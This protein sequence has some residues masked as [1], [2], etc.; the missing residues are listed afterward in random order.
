MRGG[1]KYHFDVLIIGAGM[2]GA[3]VA[4]RLAPDARVAL[5]EMEDQPGYHTTGRSA[6]IFTE[7]YGPPV[8]RA[9]TSLSRDFLE[10]PP[11]GFAE[12]PL[13][14]PRGILTFAADSQ[15]P[16]LDQLFR[17]YGSVS[18]IRRVERAEIKTLV[19]LLRDDFAISGLLE[20]NARDIDVHALHQGF[21][22][23]I[24]KQGGAVLT[25]MEVKRID[26]AGS[27]WALHT[28][29]GVMSAPVIVNAAG[30]WADQIA[31]MAGAATVG[32]V[33]KRRTVVIVE[34]PAGVDATAWP[35]VGDVDD[36]FY[37]KPDSGRF[38]LSPADE[39]PSAPCDAQP[40]EL[41]VATCIERVE[42]AFDLKIRRIENSW[43]GLRSF[44]ADQAPACGF[45]P[46]LDGFFW[47]VGQGGHGIQSAPALSHLAA[48]L[49]RGGGMPRD[50]IDRGISLNDV[51]PH[52][53][54]TRSPAS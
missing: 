50:L 3:S 27:A 35:A 18:G 16:K 14:S 21:L 45:D 46:R 24:R 6:A 15:L 32:I 22:R 23:G 5:V 42:K 37:L 31:A 7:T 47:L 40:D 2:A 33:P 29:K 25:G 4:W 30:A 48:T 12:A 34:A 1:S 28:R 36:T 17:T 51:S 26:G 11:D 39:T 20:E 52:R 9:L 10:N 53:F 44:V 8:M 38:L 49:I 43:A 19:P 41:D 54:E 13:L